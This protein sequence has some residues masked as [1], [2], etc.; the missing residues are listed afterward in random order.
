MNG[1]RQIY[2]KKS[3]LKSHATDLLISAALI[4]VCI[5]F[6]SH[7]S[8]TELV[9]S[10]RKDWAS[11]RCN[12]I[13]MPFAGVIMPV[14]GQSGIK[15]NSM[16]FDYC[17]QHDVSAVLKTALMPLEYIGFVIIR[18][19]DILVYSVIA[20]MAFLEY[21]KSILGG[22]FSMVFM[23]IADMLVPLTVFLIRTR[24]NMAKMNA[25]MLTTLFSTLVIYRITISGMINVM[26]IMTNLML[27]L[28]GV[29]VGMFILAAILL[30][31]PFTTIPG[32][33]LITSTLVII[34]AVLVPAI[35]LYAM[36]HTF[37]MNTFGARTDKPPSIPTLNKKKKQ[38]NNNNNNNNNNKKNNN[39][40]KK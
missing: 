3:Y 2:S 15:T 32:L 40:K 37:L 9:D 39:K 11:N 26:T 14:E 23:K 5:T 31:N 38:G 17:A 19:I 36:L 7:A 30:F 18:S 1:V 33:I 8:Y 6:V 34:A 24:D 21:L 10:V 29:L 4:I 22:L 13:Y 28:I 25:I 35:V 27:A 16:N 20:S 12:P